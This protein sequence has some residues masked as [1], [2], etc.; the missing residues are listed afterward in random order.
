M[1]PETSL[2]TVW[3][4]RFGQGWIPLDIQRI[5]PIQR[6]YPL[7]DSMRMHRALFIRHRACTPTPRQL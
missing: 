6:R 3:S 4:T 2:S 7:P 5:L 1:T